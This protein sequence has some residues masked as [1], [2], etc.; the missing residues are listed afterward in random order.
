MKNQKNG[1]V[2]NQQ[3]MYA[4]DELN[5]LVSIT[6]EMGLNVTYTYDKAG[7]RIS[8]T[9][10]GGAGSGVPAM[11]T[12]QAEP[13]SQTTT[14]PPAPAAQQLCGNCGTPV[15][16]GKKFCRNCGVPVSAPAPAA[17]ATPAPPQSVCTACGN[18]LRPGAKFCGKC[19]R[20]LT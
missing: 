11:S 10:S 2:M 4:Y 17:T 19:G 16:P 9:R 14:L 8:V 12:V 3:R 7:N 5:N 6:N 15:T 18:P 13:R 20:K 1:G